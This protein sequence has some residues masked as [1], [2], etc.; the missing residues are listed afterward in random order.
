MRHSYEAGVTGQ[1]RARAGSRPR[2]RDDFGLKQTKVI[3]I[4]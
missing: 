1:L 2:G 4:D 3:V